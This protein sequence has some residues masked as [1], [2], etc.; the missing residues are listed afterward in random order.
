VSVSSTELQNL[1]PKTAEVGRA[2]HVE[3]QRPQSQ[4]Q[5]LAATFAEQVERRQ[6]QVGQ[7]PQVDSGRVR[8]RQPHGRRDSDRQEEPDGS[9]DRRGND[10]AGERDAGACAGEAG[11]VLDVRV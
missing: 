9:P 2:Q 4:Q 1:I 7:P 10:E 5:Q 6:R 11:R 8:D 3:N